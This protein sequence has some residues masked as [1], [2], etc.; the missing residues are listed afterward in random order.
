MKKPSSK[1]VDFISDMDRY[2]VF[3]EVKNCTGDENNCNWRVHPNNSKVGFSPT[4]VDVEDR[5]SADIETARKVAMTMAAL[6]GANTFGEGKNSSAEL[7]EYI[8]ALGS[9][10]FS[11]GSK[12]LLVVLFL[13]GNFGSKTN[14]KKMIMKRLG[15]SL[16]KKLQWL[17][18]RASVVDS[19]TYD[20]RIFEAVN[21]ENK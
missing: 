8:K 21:T 18:C 20:R 6:S 3:T 17:K 15:D 1:G 7:E 2:F 19:N 12:R 13:E 14:S 10:D 9:K 11:K 16:N 4:S 5:D